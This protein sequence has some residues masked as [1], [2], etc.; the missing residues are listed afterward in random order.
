LP[1]KD[2]W[3][4]LQELKEDPSTRDIPVVIA[5]IVEEPERGFSLGAADY[6]LKP[7]DREDFL[8]RLSRYGFTAKHLGAPVRALI[9]DDDPLAVEGLVGVLA[10]AGF[11]IAKAYGGRQGLEIA[12]AERPDLIVLDLV[13]PEISGFEVAQRLKEHPDTKEIPIFVVSVKDLT[14][15]DKQKLNSLVAAVMPKGTFSGEELLAEIGK[16]LRLKTVR[17]GR[18]QE[19]G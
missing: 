5:S 14:E 1:K 12:L 4:V 6:I 15:E 10:P 19:G 8:R 2:G 7:F 18:V 3:E 9:I 17:E 16:L 11:S 13:M